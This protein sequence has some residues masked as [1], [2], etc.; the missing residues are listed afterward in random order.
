MKGVA[1]PQQGSLLPTKGTV[2]HLTV[3]S[4][5]KATVT[6]RLTVVYVYTQPIS[7]AK[8]AVRKV[9]KK[10]VPSVMTTLKVAHL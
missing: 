3:C 2:S 1:Q 10:A 8:L 5:N 6:C 4:I 7:L 9:T